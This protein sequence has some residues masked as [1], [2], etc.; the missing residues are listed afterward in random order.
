MKKN[1]ILSAHNELTITEN[2]DFAVRNE[3]IEQY[4]II[5]FHTHIYECIYAGLPPIIR[6][7]TKKNSNSFFD[8]S[9]YPGGV[10]NF[11]INK[12]GYRNWPETVFSKEGMN[13]LL[14]LYGKGVLSL[15]RSAT[16]ERLIHD[17]EKSSINKSVVL[18]INIKNGNE[19]GE[20]NKAING[21]DRFI[22]FGSV[23]PFDKNIE[24]QIDHQLKIG[25]KGF[26]INPHVWGIDFDSAEIRNL[27]GLLKET[28]KPIISC[29]GIA[30]PPTF[31]HLPKGLWR[32]MR[33]QDV[34]KFHYALKQFPDIKLIFAH[35]G[36]E[37]N[38][39]L[40]K[41]MEEFPNA[42]SDI[43]LQPSD[44]IQNMIKK[45]GCERLLFGSDYPFINQA[46]P[47][48]SVLK[49]TESEIERKAIFRENAESILEQDY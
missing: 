25:I 26:K 27:I 38:K 34:R 45:I 47:I 5:D 15:I 4:K 32:N 12:I 19:T 31:R 29:S 16:K 3:L 33:T 30:I 24:Q 46:F 20:T 18:P 44:N 2:G 28:Q 22:L 37:Q 1:D 7:K 9:C 43:S 17:M 40:I 10:S 48:L 13:T 49:A 21:D 36:L 8:L 42:Y 41:L 23:H 39:D 14:R 11:S 6:R 35:G